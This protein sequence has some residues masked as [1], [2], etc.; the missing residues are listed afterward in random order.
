[1]PLLTLPVGAPVGAGLAELG[2]QWTGS[3]S[4]PDVLR[5]HLASSDARKRGNFSSFIENK[6]NFSSFIE[7]GA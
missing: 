2:G 7:P 1:M 5:A 3:T 6:G 4:V